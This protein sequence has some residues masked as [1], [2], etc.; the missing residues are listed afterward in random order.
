MSKR[1]TFIAAILA[2]F[3]LAGPAVADGNGKGP[4]YS[5]PSPLTPQSYTIYPNQHASPAPVTT[6]NRGHVSHSG[7]STHT[8]HSGHS[9]CGH[10]GG[11][12]S[13][14]GLATN[15]VSTCREHTSAHVTYTPAPQVHYAPAPAP[16][17]H[18]PAPV[19]HQPVQQTNYVSIDTSGFSGGVG[20]GVNDV[21]VG[22]GGFGD[23]GGTAFGARANGAFAGRNVAFSR[24]INGFRGGRRGGGF[25][26]GRGAGFKGGRGGGRR[27]GRGGRGG[28]GKR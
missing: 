19:V 11:G 28:G 14:S 24:S 6:Y 22:G 21:Y 8:Y 3:A 7:H 9:G 25:K 20:V 15:P 27:G 2:S 17:Y 10:S 16:I 5:A 12:L 1:F 4:V 26:G 13:Y 23:G 18:T